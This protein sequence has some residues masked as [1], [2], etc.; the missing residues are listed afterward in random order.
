M[1]WR[2]ITESDLKT[3]LSPDELDLLRRALGAEASDTIAATINLLADELRGH[4]STGG[5]DVDATDYTLPSSLIGRAVQIAILRIS[6]RAGGVLPDPKKLREKAHDAAEKFFAE[7]VAA[8][9]FA[10]ETPSTPSSAAVTNAPSGPS[11]TAKSLYIQKADQE[12][13]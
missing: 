1:S 12:G 5:S 11:M 7:V 13:T 9:K 4:I 3:A 2:T 8:G 10:I 6:T